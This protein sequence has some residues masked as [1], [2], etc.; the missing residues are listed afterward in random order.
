MLS[1]DGDRRFVRHEVNGASSFEFSDGQ[2]TIEA[3]TYVDPDTQFRTAWGLHLV[4]RQ[5]NND[6][7]GI[8]YINYTYSCQNLTIK[9]YAATFIML[10]YTII[11]ILVPTIDQ[12]ILEINNNTNASA[13]G[14]TSPSSH[15]LLISLFGRKCLCGLPIL[16]AF[17]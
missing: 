14:A 9:Y 1:S 3:H 2:F 7:L 11:Y 4:I 10:H 17:L 16:L 15:S 13:S 8:Q 6:E 12:K 5:I